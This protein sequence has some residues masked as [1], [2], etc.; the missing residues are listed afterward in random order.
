MST[1]HPVAIKVIL[2]CDLSCNDPDGLLSFARQSRCFSCLSVRYWHLSRGWLPWL[3]QLFEQPHR[4]FPKDWYDRKRPLTC[5]SLRRRE[6]RGAQPGKEESQRNLSGQ[7]SLLLLIVVP[8]SRCF[9]HHPST[10]FR[11]KSSYLTLSPPGQRHL[12]HFLCLTATFFLSTSFYSALFKPITPLLT[13]S[14]FLHTF[15]PRLLP[16]DCCDFSSGFN[17][18]TSPH[19][20][21]RPYASNQALSRAGV[22]SLR[23]NRC[24]AVSRRRP[25]GY[26]RASRKP[27]SRLASTG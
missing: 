2:F 21:K 19:K 20:L 27:S 26:L 3:R 17:S 12:L 9:I 23:C 13:H 4:V 24:G 16:T 25:C 8:S 7:I 14:T 22:C 1:A 18:T 6:R 11:D 15:D 5:W 10:T